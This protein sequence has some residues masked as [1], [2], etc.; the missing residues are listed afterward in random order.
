MNANY[1]ILSVT[2]LIALLALLTCFLLPRG[3]GINQPHSIPNAETDSTAGVAS[4]ELHNAKSETP[5]RRASA[6]VQAQ[7]E[8]RYG[9]RYAVH[10]MDPADLGE[11]ER[12][13]LGVYLVKGDTKK[14]LG[15]TSLSHESYRSKSHL[16]VAIAGGKTMIERWGDE[17]YTGMAWAFPDDVKGEFQS[18]NWPDVAPVIM[19]KHEAERQALATN[20]DGWSVVV[21]FWKFTPTNRGA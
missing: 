13:H 17:G 12:A 18:L 19:L 3:N 6:E 10:K 21:E 20:P 1:K 5:A 16:A 15:V 4:A 14:E 2:G 9:E 8:E 7:M 11:G